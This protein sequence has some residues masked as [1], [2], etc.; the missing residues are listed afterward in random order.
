MSCAE[1]E[2]DRHR[3]SRNELTSTSVEV[4]VDTSAEDIQSCLYYG[5][6]HSMAQD[7]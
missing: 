2:W 4:K 7:L 6:H 1:V 3:S 5:G